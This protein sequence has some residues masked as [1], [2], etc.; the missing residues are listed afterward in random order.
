[1]CV[2]SSVFELFNIWSTVKEFATQWE[3]KSVHVVNDNVGAVCIAARGCLR[4]VCLHAL[5]VAVLRECWRFNIKLSLQFLSGEGIVEA[6]ADGLSRGSDWG[7]CVLVASSFA[8]L[9]AWNMVEVDLFC[10]PGAIQWEPRTGIQLEAVSPY[11]VE[12]QLGWDGLQ[13]SSKKR[14]YAFPPS[15]LLLQLMSRV[16]TLGL[17][18]VI[19]GPV[20]PAAP[21]WPLVVDKP[22]LELGLVAN[23]I[24]PGQSKVEHPF[25]YSYDA[26][27]AKRQTMRAWAF[28]M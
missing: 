3:G 17:Q 23:C 7:D 4:N 14:L 2:H 8:R 15:N 27:A 13:F 26:E 11:P 18:A 19:V 9:F 6:G 25:G 16:V 20:W 28:N 24:R 1:M 10:A 21:W 22:F 5:A 12:R